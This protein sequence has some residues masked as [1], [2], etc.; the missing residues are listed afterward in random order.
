MWYIFIIIIAICFSFNFPVILGDTDLQIYGVIS[1]YDPRKFDNNVKAQVSSKCFKGFNFLTCQ[2]LNLKDETYYNDLSYYQNFATV[3]GTN[4]C[5]QCCGAGRN[6]DVWDLGCAV[7]KFSATETNLYGK[8]VI[9]AA[10]DGTTA[11]NLIICQIKRTG[12]TYDPDTG[13][14]IECNTATNITYLHGYTL[15]INVEYRHNNLQSLWRQVMSCDVESHESLTSL[16]S[17]PPDPLLLKALSEKSSFYHG[18]FPQKFPGSIVINNRIRNNIKKIHILNEESKTEGVLDE[19]ALFHLSD[20]QRKFKLNV[21]PHVLFSAVHHPTPP[22]APSVLGII[23]KDNN[24]QLPEIESVNDDDDDDVVDSE[25]NH[26]PGQAVSA[27]RSHAK[28]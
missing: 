2:A 21:H 10:K 4:Y 18:T 26:T 15:T 23:S 27:A 5:L 1:A 3:Y 19:E 11:N 16:K 8:A 7:D 12:C 24:N 20:K 13:L 28:Q 25:D 9:L 17:E 6:T 22:P 14:V